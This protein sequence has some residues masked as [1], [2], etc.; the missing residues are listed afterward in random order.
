M[1]HICE[2]IGLRLI[3]DFGS[4]DCRF[5]FEFRPFEGG[6]VFLDNCDMGGRIRIVEDIQNRYAFPVLLA[7]LAHVEAAILP[8]SLIG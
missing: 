3:G 4:F 6:N 8:T 1:A 5:E 7:R 2:E